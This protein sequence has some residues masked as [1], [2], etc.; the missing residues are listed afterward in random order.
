MFTFFFRAIL[1]WA[2]FLFFSIL[3][4]MF[5][6]FTCLDLEVKSYTSLES[7]GAI[8]NYEGSDLPLGKLL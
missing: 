5:E 8:K 4:H 6:I 1:A 3:P 7:F 2:I